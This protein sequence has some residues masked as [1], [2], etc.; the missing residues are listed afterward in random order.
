MNINALIGSRIC[1]DLINPLGAISNGVELLGLDGRVSGPEYDLVVSSVQ[2]ATA[3]IKLMRLAFGDADIN[4]NVNLT[5]L[6]D[7][8]QRLSSEG[9][10]KYEW[11]EPDAAQPMTARPIIRAAL[12]ANMC[13]E[14]ALPT[15]GVITTNYLNNGYQI[16]TK[17]AQLN[18]DPALWVPLSRGEVPDQLTAS[19]VHFALFNAMTQDAGLIAKLS[20]GADW[21]QITLSH[22]A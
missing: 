14:T 5:D 21:L 11:Q 6:L 17:S 19:K 2:S 10:I 18:L 12:L 20:H 4:Q 13:V 9:R 3:K 15:G 7:I 16:Y 8:L 22:K 1:H